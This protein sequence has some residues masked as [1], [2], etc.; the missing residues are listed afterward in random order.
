M[1]T[2]QTLV[3]LYAPDQRSDK[4]HFPHRRSSR[5]HIKLSVTACVTYASGSTGTIGAMTG[6]VAKPGDGLMT[7]PPPEGMLMMT[8]LVITG[9]SGHV[10]HSMR[11]LDTPSCRMQ[12]C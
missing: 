3:T 4:Q 6:D 1:V 12:C 2:G 10:A 8:A 7:H 5:H 9:S 11:T